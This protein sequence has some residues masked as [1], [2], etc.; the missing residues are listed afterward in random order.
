MYHRLMNRRTRTGEAISSDDA[1]SFLRQRHPSEVEL[2]MEQRK[3]R[4]LEDQNRSLMLRVMQLE[5]RIQGVTGGSAHGEKGETGSTHSYND[6]SGSAHTNSDSCGPLATN[7]DGDMDT[8][9][10]H[11]SDLDSRLRGNVRN[12]SPQKDQDLGTLSS[13]V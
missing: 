13:P 4:K 12:R 11:T 2:N 7:P 6:V 10:M 5:Q 3:T 1:W 9:S 8:S